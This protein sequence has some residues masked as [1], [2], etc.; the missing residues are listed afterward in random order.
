MAMCMCV[1]C[2]VS[3]GVVTLIVSVCRGCAAVGVV[4]LMV[5][6][7]LLWLSGMRVTLSV[8]PGATFLWPEFGCS[9]TVAMHRLRCL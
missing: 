2:L 9:M 5:M 6:C 1:L 8:C 7:W 4:S 3:V